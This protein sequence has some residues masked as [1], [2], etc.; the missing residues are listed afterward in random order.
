MQ[1]YPGA[2]VRHSP[3]VGKRAKNLSAHPSLLLLLQKS[4][5]AQKAAAHL[6]KNARSSVALARPHYEGITGGSCGGRWP[7]QGKCLE[8]VQETVERSWFL[9][10]A[11]ESTLQSTDGSSCIA[12]CCSFCRLA[13]HTLPTSTA[14][15][16]LEHQA[17]FLA[18]RPCSCQ[19]LFFPPTTISRSLLLASAFRI[20][21]HLLMHLKLHQTGKCAHSAALQRK[22]AIFYLNASNLYS[23]ITALLLLH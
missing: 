13:L 14:R 16:L 18:L 22:S 10:E 11:R 2:V 17:L 7:L 5:P 21:L 20:P 3:T 19:G 6:H 12:M 8:A 23:I 4:S 1:L 15:K 9:H